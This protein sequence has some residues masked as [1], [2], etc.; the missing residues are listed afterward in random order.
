M[1]TAI[2]V[3]PLAAAREVLLPV[4]ASSDPSQALVAAKCTGLM[5]GYHARWQNA[6]YTI[7]AVEHVSTSDLYNPETQRT[8]R[9]F[10]VAGKLDVIATDSAEREV[11]FDHKTT[12]QDITDPNGPYW[13][14]LAIEGQVS[15]YMLLEFLNGNKIDYAVWDVL[16]KPSIS[17]K[18][19]NKTERAMIAATKEY[20][21]SRDFN[22]EEF[23]ASERETHAM[24][25]LRLAH[26]CT[27]ERP[28]WY[29]QRRQVPRL[30]S[31]IHEYAGELWDHSQDLIVARRTGRWPR[32]SGACM[33]YNTP[34]K[35]LGICS[36]YDTAES[37]NWGQKPWVHSELP[38]LNGDGKDILTNSRIRTFQTCRRKHQLQYEIGIERIDEEEKESLFFGSLFHS[39]LEAY[40]L[41]LKRQQE[42]A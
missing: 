23:A 40:F 35:F 11:I 21:G 13:R 9:T 5:A 39:T 17:P 15:H 24:Y 33:S 6:P 7:R 25:A 34:C 42:S 30:D 37:E 32:N 16:R 4:M 12:S 3:S 36:G 38:I 27:H 2:E 29:F 1:I 10:S 22:F 18:L 20:Y 41:E 28:D 26:D 14:Q 31:E 8:S 19:L